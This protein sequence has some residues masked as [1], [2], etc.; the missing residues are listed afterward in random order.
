MDDAP[1]ILLVDDDIDSADMLAEF[2]G[3]RG[4]GQ[5]RCAHDAPQAIEL[6]REFSPT[7][8]LLDIQLPGAIDGCELARR[9]RVEVPDAKLIAVSGYADQAHRRRALKAG[10]VDYM[11]KPVH[12]PLLDVLLAGSVN[13]SRDA[14]RISR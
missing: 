1:R 5:A 4:Y 8:V 11:T 10:C 9:L 2:I 6:A 13:A 7:L 14:H 12:F 3:L